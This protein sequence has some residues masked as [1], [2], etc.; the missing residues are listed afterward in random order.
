MLKKIIERRVY[1]V[2]S[3]LAVYW[4]LLIFATSLPSSSLPETSIGD[5]YLH[6]L[7][8]WELGVLLSLTIYVQEKYAGLKKFYGLFGLLAASLYAVIDEVH[9]LFI[10]GRYCDILDVAADIA[11]AVVG[12]V[13]IKIIIKN[14]FPAVLNN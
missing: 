2:Y 4:V 3:P 6:F 11:G 9:Q 1:L 7:A 5:K 12:V 14:C 10:P 8:F 13:L